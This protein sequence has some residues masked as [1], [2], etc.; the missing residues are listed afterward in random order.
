LEAVTKEDL[1]KI[2]IT[3]R[4]KRDK[5]SISHLS[6]LL[7]GYGKI[8]SIVQHSERESDTI[9]SSNKRTIESF[10]V[11]IQA[12]MNE[13]MKEQSKYNEENLQDWYKKML[14]DINKIGIKFAKKQNAEQDTK[15]EMVMKVLINPIKKVL[16]KNKSE[17]L[18][19]Q[20]GAAVRSYSEFRAN[21][22]NF[23]N[24][25][26]RDLFD[27]ENTILPTIIIIL[28]YN[29]D[30]IEKALADRE[31]QQEEYKNSINNQ[32]K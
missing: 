17:I 21:K 8:K 1:Y 2:I 30:N 25:L 29:K 12:L 19:G 6:L 31:T 3:K 9:H 11:A 27:L 22:I 7:K 14:D 28:E 24:K 4:N 16:K 18:S 13:N 20:L 32:N 15:L 23:V 26:K 5:S 10:G